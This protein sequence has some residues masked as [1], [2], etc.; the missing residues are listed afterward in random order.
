[1]WGQEWH[2]RFD[3]LIP[4]PNAPLLNITAILV[5]KKVSVHDMFLLAEDYYKS[6]GLYS[7]T[8]KFWAYSLFQKPKD[9]RVVC[10]AG[11][12]DMGY[13]NDYRVKMCTKINGE[14]FYV[15]HHEM[16]HI[17]YYMS[18]DKKQPYHYQ[19]AANG[20]FDEAVGDT[21]AL[22]ASA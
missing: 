12:I 17:E 5:E 14:N 10:H 7:M 1:M 9:R 16:G 15:V 20:G 22:F 4:F 13:H 6:I 8:K 3:D 19:E 18:Y 2:N 21:I 11:S